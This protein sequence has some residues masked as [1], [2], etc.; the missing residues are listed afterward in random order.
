[1]AM[2]AI[3]AYILPLPFLG[4]EIFVGLI[5]AFIFSL[6]TLVYF[7]IA[8]TDHDAHDDKHTEHEHSNK[9]VHAT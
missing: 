8:A 1:M 3:L 7:T 2:G 6:L 9:V 5:Q 4:L